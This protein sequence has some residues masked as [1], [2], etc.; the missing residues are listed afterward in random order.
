MYANFRAEFRNDGSE[1]Q[2][3]LKQ[4]LPSDDRKSNFEGKVRSMIAHNMNPTTSWKRGIN[5]YSDM[6]SEEFRSY[7]NIVGNT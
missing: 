1:L 6:T 5:A 2:G 7:Y 4:A 3:F